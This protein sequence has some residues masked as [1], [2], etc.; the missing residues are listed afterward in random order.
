MEEHK[1]EIENCSICC[2]KKEAETKTFVCDHLFCQKCI[3]SWYVSCVNQ[4]IQPHC[5][6]C[7]KVDNIWG[8]R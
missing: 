6:I 1:E 3:V 4:H 2:L 5:P 8:K 7:R